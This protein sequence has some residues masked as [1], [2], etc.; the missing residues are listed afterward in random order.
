MC[1]FHIRRAHVFIAACVC[2]SVYE[3]T[4]NDRKCFAVL[5][6][7]EEQEEV[8]GRSRGCERE[9][10]WSPAP[11]VYGIVNDHLLPSLFLILFVFVCVWVC[12]Q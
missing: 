6:P 7:V 11:V 4:V 9:Q 8:E 1:E 5:Q 3:D 12:V 10:D 2:A